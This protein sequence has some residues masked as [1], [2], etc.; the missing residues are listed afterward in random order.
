MRDEMSI[1][2]ELRC[3][4]L[5]DVNVEEV[6]FSSTEVDEGSAVLTDEPAVQNLVR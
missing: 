1:D 4:L 2:C 6:S 5:L 3:G